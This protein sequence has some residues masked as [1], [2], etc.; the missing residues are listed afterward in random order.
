M[1]LSGNSVYLYFF[2]SVVLGIPLVI[3]LLP[4]V[5]LTVLLKKVYKATCKP[6]PRAPTKVDLAPPSA[7][8]VRAPADRSYDIVLMGATGFTGRLA[9]KYLAAQY[10]ASSASSPVKW[11][12]AGRKQSK[13]EEVRAELAATDAA[14]A[15][16]PI[17]LADSFDADS[18]RAL[19][20]DTR[21]VVSTV[22]PFA[23]YGTGLVQCCTQFGTHYCDITGESD[24]M[25]EMIDRFDDQVRVQRLA[26]MCFAL[27]EMRSTITGPVAVPLHFCTTQRYADCTPDAGKTKGSFHDILIMGLYRSL[28]NVMRLLV[29]VNISPMHINIHTYTLI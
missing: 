17:I 21:C 19:C 10:G 3:L 13:L 23:R 24:W 8:Q 14:L 15:N 2:F 22:G 7:D 16:L 29:D 9:A 6:R 18:L 1:A 25:R 27:W 11:A 5:L 4:F 20:N 28:R 12:I 26:G